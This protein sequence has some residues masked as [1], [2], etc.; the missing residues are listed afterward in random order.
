ME[1]DFVSSH[2]GQLAGDIDVSRVMVTNQSLK[3]ILEQI[4]SNF[5]GRLDKITVE[6]TPRNSDTGRASW[7]FIF[8]DKSTLRI[9]MPGRDPRLKRKGF[10]SDRHTHAAKESPEGYPVSDTGRYVPPATEVAH[11]PVTSAHVPAGPEPAQMPFS[12]FR[13]KYSTHWR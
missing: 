7:K 12:E 1:E 11:V 13:N 2:L 3:N 6:L 10:W 4:V 5:E 9:D 8:P